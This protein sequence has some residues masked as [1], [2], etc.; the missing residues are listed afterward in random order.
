MKITSVEFVRSVE[1]LNEIPKDNLN[2]IAF[3]GR[4]NVGK[5][6]L[7]NCLLNRKKLAKTSSTPGKTRQLN[8]FRINRA[9]YF[10]DL[11]GYGFARVSKRERVHWRE[12]VEGYIQRSPNLKGVVSI[13]DCRVGLTELDLQLLEWLKSLNIPLVVV[14]TKSDKLSNNALTTQVSKISK[15][16]SSHFLR[17]IY[18]FSAVSGMGK[19][20]VWREILTLL[21]L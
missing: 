5:S 17:N 18:P 2:E 10:V 7:I 19:K 13:V 11:P 16:L 20:E 4:S 3:A 6:S 12:L 8:Y 21:E 1:N 15:Q 9:F 14:A